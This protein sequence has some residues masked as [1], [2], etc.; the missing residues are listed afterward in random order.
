M[1]KTRLNG[2]VR[3]EMDAGLRRGIAAAVVLLIVC[4]LAV[5][6]V[7]AA[8]TVTVS[9]FD[10][11]QNNIST[12]GDRTIIVSAS[13]PITNQLTINSGNITLTTDGA[14]HTLSRGNSFTDNLFT[15]NSGGSL[16]IRGNSTHDTNLTL[17]GMKQSPS[18]NLVKVSGSFTLADGG[19]LTNNT[20]FSGGG[21]YVFLGGTFT[22]SGGTISDNTANN[23]YGGGVYVMS[24]GSTFEM[25]GGTISGNTADDGGG[26][27]MM[28]SGST[29]EMSGGTISG[30]TADDG[31]GVYVM[32]D[33]STFTMSDDAVISENTASNNGGGVYVSSGTF[34]MS[35]GEIS[36]NT[37]EW[38]G[39]GVYEDNSGTFGMSGDAVISGNTADYGGG[40]S[41]YSSG[42][43]EMSGN[44]AISGNTAVSGGGVYVS[45]GTFEMS[46]DAVISGNTAPKGGGVY[47][48]SGTFEM[49]GGEIS[50]NTAS[51]NGGGVYVSGGEFTMSGDAVIS[52]NTAS[53]NGGGVCMFGSSTFKL[54][55]SGSTD[56][57][58]LA[59]GK[60]ITVTGALTGTDPQ[61]T[62]IELADLDDGTA[63][64]TGTP[65]QES[66]LSHFKL[67]SSVTGFKLA[68]QSPDSIVL[69]VQPD[70]TVQFDAQG[71]SPEPEDVTV[72]YGGMVT[73]PTETPVKT[74]YTFTGWFKDTVQWNFETPVTSNMILYANW[75]A[76]MYTVTFDAQG[77]SP[78]PADVTVP[79]GGMV[80]EPTETP[81]KTGYT[82]TGW[83]KEEECTNQWDFDT[84]MVTGDITLYA[85]WKKDEPGPGPDPTP[86][87]PSYSSGDG[88]MENAFRVLFN[89]GATTLTVQ[90]D[91]SYGDKLT[92]PEDPVKE[93][94][95]FAGWYKDEACTQGWDFETGIPGD[96][97]LY[98]K[99]TA[100]EATPTA[101]A[102]ATAVTTPQPTATQ[103][104]AAATSVPEATT[105]AAVSPTLVQTP[106][107][108]AGALFG[109]LAAGLLLRRRFQ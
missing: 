98:A 74:G 100:I 10:E 103:T 83:Y 57:V 104:T 22:M 39:G 4:V 69:K 86:L 28:S 60:S 73:E 99:W 33:G 37:A 90:T 41:V 26:V 44:A 109:L 15:V 6:V 56:S 46:G 96:M 14:D 107:P 80:T 87:P 72:P 19:I 54:S 64:V 75:T 16:T 89:D 106:A 77:G 29:F 47:L 97:T 51:N 102:T 67:D 31:G 95:T 11:L 71:G 7:S 50:V 63:V 48:S 20:A 108:V 32:S 27:Y 58:Y 9:S 84:D 13:F 49:S 82:F 55:G 66:Y 18:D 40:V 21:V 17:D 61:V 43:F 93:G 94:Y 59:S 62:G 68:Y 91:L 24:D 76:N 45:S 53:N 30:N 101:T 5:G 38:Y 34:T 1:L 8:D 35:G 105:A 3:P 88:N 42:T 23:G 36:N 2:T 25:S 78:K 52:G 81:V 65:L 92:K 70:C 79:Y 85:G 12:F